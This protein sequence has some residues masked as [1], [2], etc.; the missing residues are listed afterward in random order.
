MTE[1]GCL[2]HTLHFLLNVVLRRCSVL[3]V[4]GT[5]GVA[6]EVQL[7]SPEMLSTSA[8]FRRLIGGD[9]GHCLWMSSPLR[10]TSAQAEG[11]K[12]LTESSVR[13]M[14]AQSK[15]SMSWSDLLSRL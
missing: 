4:C 1:M 9:Q 5:G 6:A 11:A 13:C 10:L 14:H 12:G 8:E 7:P 3:P 2:G 15:A